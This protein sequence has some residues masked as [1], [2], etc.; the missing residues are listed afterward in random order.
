[1]RNVAFSSEFPLPFSGSEFEPT[2][3]NF[4]GRS[5]TSAAIRVSTLPPR[6]RGNRRSG[7]ESRNSFAGADSSPGSFPLR[8]HPPDPRSIVVVVVDPSPTSPVVSLRF[9][10]PRLS[11]SNG[12]AEGEGG[13]KRWN[14]RSSSPL[15]TSLPSISFVPSLDGPK[16]SLLL[17]LFPRC[18]CSRRSFSTGSPGSFRRGEGTDPVSV[19]LRSC[20]SAGFETKSSPIRTRT[21]IDDRQRK[22]KATEFR[23]GMGARR[24]RGIVRVES[25]VA[26]LRRSDDDRG[27]V[28]VD[29]E[30]IRVD[31]DGA[32]TRWIERGFRHLAFVPYRFPH[33]S[34]PS[35]RDSFV[36]SRKRFWYDEVKDKNG[37]SEVASAPSLEVRR[38]LP[39]IP[40]R[41]TRPSETS[42]SRSRKRDARR[43]MKETT[44]PER[45]NRCA[46]AE[47]NGGNPWKRF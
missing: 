31:A 16:R 33:R 15:G 12:D 21:T 29:R 3:A 2:R 46:M 26:D 47:R 27:R 39:P 18:S 40:F 24:K 17:R 8:L 7:R 22:Q 32:R 6:S 42:F 23:T 25:A 20:R 1:M 11:A 44:R 10:L 30:R 4:F 13:S 45:S 34:L 37:F 14:F 19:G 41:A 43:A 38:W 35:Y 36:R 9:F 5:S 28:E